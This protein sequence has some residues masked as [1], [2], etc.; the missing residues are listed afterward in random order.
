VTG[1]ET[2]DG[3]Q[4]RD[5][6]IYALSLAAELEH[7]ICLQYLYAAYTLKTTADDGLTP[8]QAATVN[9]WETVL[10]EIARQEMGHVGLV[11][12][13]LTA[14]GGSPHF[15]RPNFP[16]EDRY[17]NTRIH[18][19][20]RPLTRE[21]LQDFI[22][23]ERPRPPLEAALADTPVPIPFNYESIQ[24][25]YQFIDEGFVCLERKLR[26]KEKTTLFIGP[27]EAQIDSNKIG[28]V[29]E[30]PIYD[31]K[32]SRVTNLNEARKAIRQIVLEGEGSPKKE[33]KASA[34]SH[35]KRLTSIE[36]E[37]SK[38]NEFVPHRNVIHNPATRPDR[39][40]WSDGANLIT[41]P[42]TCKVAHLSNAAYEILL[43]TLIRFYAQI[44]ATKAELAT[45]QYTSFFP[46]MVM[47][48]RPAA[49]LLSTLP[50]GPEYHGKRAGPPFEFYGHVQLLPHRRSA[51]Q[52]LYEKLSV[53]AEYCAELAKEAAAD[54]A[55]EEMK[56]AAPR[57]EF[58]RQNTW[59]IAHDF[60][61][62]M[63]VS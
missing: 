49:E 35:Y 50:A 63:G 1:I 25:L 33:D 29:N 26:K 27:P 61:M 56:A 11:N 12:N 22:E 10:L 9:R 52:V 46:L 3:I 57:L 42:F 39:L 18:L 53:M 31:V 60:K 28:L 21:T 15:H 44:D 40:R 7:G 38:K 34:D 47:V 23:V 37:Y 30:R 24:E 45:L 5:D 32:L 41:D 59:R 14:I 43:M 51:W 36:K 54:N 4:T 48:V 55:S 2:V 19:R 6:L 58:M 16:Q 8:V 17:G 20:L 62:A 13:L